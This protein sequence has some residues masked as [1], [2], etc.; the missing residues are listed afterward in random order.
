MRKTAIAAVTAVVAAAGVPA[1]A[2]TVKFTGCPVRAA[3]GCL[4]VRNGA[5]VYNISTAQPAPR[6]GYRAISATAEISGSIGL[7]FAK[8]LSHIRWHYLRRQK[9][10]P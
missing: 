1:M 8:P 9:C 4:I 3:E 7:C 10:A 5:I 6:V 2:E